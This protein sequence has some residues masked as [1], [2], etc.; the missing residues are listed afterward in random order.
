MIERFALP[1]LSLSDRARP[2][3]VWGLICT[4]WG[5]ACFYLF[6]NFAPNRGLTMGSN[7]FGHGDVFGILAFLP[8]FIAAY[9]VIIALAIAARAAFRTSGQT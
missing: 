2:W 1:H 6:A 3:V 5:N 7:R 9:L 8:A 4:A